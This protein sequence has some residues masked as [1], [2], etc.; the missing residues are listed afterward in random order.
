MSRTTL[1]YVSKEK[2]NP[3]RIF[4]IVRDFLCMLDHICKE[5]RSSKAQRSPNPNGPFKYIT[6]FFMCTYEYASP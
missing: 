6:L 1:V 3:L 2:A 4:V 5:L